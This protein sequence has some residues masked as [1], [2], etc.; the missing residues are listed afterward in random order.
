[1]FMAYSLIHSFTHS[2]PYSLTLTSAIEAENVTTGVSGTAVFF[3]NVTGLANSASI[4]YK[5]QSS[6][7][8]I[9]MGFPIEVFG[10]RQGVTTIERL[11]LSNVR[12]LDGEYD[13]NCQIS[14][15]SNNKII[16]DTTATLTTRSKSLTLPPSLPS[17]L[18]PSLPPSLLPLFPPSLSVFPN[19]R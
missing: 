3:C 11:T 9:V 1:M 14:A 8:G 5:W 2:L 15:T 12:E 7:N 16:G 18:P 6:Q 19:C 4:Q 17:S 10:N 13:Y